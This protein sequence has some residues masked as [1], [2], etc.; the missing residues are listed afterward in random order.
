GGIGGIAHHPSNQGDYRRPPLR[1]KRGYGATGGIGGTT[2]HSDDR[3]QRS[4]PRRNLQGPNGGVIW[5]GSGNKLLP[6]QK[7]RRVWRR[8]NDRYRFRGD[9]G[10]PATAAESWADR[11]LR[12]R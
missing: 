1:P 4:V 11:S 8:R 2:W 3:R 7:P 6:Q 9:G 12:Q 10:P 5:R